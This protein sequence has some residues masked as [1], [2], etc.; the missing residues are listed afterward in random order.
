M[1]FPSFKSPLKISFLRNISLIEIVLFILFVSYII[2]PIQTPPAFAPVIDSPLGMGFMLCVTVALF[3][4]TNPVLGILYIFV[5]Y[6]A[7]RRSAP[8]KFQTIQYPTTPNAKSIQV[9]KHVPEMPASNT[10][11]EEVVATMA[12]I[13]QS[14]IGVFSASDYKPVSNKVHGASMF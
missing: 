6:E 8:I 7:I 5:A 13:G 2:F 3:F 1:K 10:L 4:Y 9:S 12:P 14:P 11:E